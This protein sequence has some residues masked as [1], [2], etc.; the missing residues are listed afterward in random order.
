MGHLNPHPRYP[1]GNNE[2]E[3]MEAYQQRVVEEKEQL[4]QKLAKLKAFFSTDL[5]R[6]LPEEDSSLMKDQA[7]CMN[8]YSLVLGKRIERFSK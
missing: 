5:F 3:F 7:F 1:R 2:S 4:D 6:N 8:E